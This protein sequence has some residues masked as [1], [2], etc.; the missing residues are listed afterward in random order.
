MLKLVK[1]DEAMR[2]REDF[3]SY[4]IGCLLDTNASFY[5]TRYDFK[6]QEK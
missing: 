1:I 5:N 6:D 3:K 2:L 4:F